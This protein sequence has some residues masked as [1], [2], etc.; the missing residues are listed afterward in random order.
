MSG[1]NYDHFVKLLIIGESGVGKTCILLR[2]ADD[3]FPI[4]HQTTV[5]VDFKQKMINF[6]NKTIKIQIWDTAG[7]ERFRTLTNNYFKPANGIIL[8]YDVSDENSFYSIKN[9]IKQ[10]ESL[11]D[12]SVCVILIGNKCEVDESVRKVKYEDA[13][14]LA[15]E[16]KIPFMETSAKNNLNISQV[17]NT[18]TKQIIDK[19][20]GNNVNASGRITLKSENQSN[21]RCY[22]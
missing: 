7:Q 22:C 20:E 12:P 5:G 11:A 13:Q 8:V 2:F 9:W 16:L 14:K 17:F 6:N 4:V 3:K 15:K 1:N 21:Q 10:I 18:I 19:L